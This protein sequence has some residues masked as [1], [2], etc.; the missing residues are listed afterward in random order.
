MQHDYDM[1][2]RRLRRKSMAGAGVHKG[3]GTPKKAELWRRRTIAGLAAEDSLSA[4]VTLPELVQKAEEELRSTPV[5]SRAGSVSA[6][7]TP[8]KTVEE[9]DV[10]QQDVW[11][12][13]EWTKA[14]WKMLDSCFTDERYHL[15]RSQGLP[16]GVLASVDDVEPQKVVERFI[17]ILGSGLTDS[18]GPSWTT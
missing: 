5:Q 17:V 1:I 3:Y 2:A 6:L 12:P 9:S 7:G 18:H 10:R 8:K 14:D 4:N 13:R 15:A 16:K 11:G